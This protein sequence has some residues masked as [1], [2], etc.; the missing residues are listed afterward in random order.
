MPLKKSRYC[1]RQR[2][3][4]RIVPEDIQRWIRECNMTRRSTVNHHCK[5]WNYIAQR[6]KFSEEYQTTPEIRWTPE[7]L[8]DK[9]IPSI[10]WIVS[11]HKTIAK[12]IVSIASKNGWKI[13]RF[14]TVNEKKRLI[15]FFANIQKRSKS[16][17]RQSLTLTSP[18]EIYNGFNPQLITFKM[19][20]WFL[21]NRSWNYCSKPMNTVTNATCLIFLI[22]KLVSI[23]STNKG[24]QMRKR[25]EVKLR[26][27]SLLRQTKVASDSVTGV[28]HFDLV[29]DLSTMQA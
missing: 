3:L 16:V 2:R 9:N 12:V 13:E 23:G 19:G 28:V 1:P 29:C 11:S 25:F 18:A 10:S 7:L 5:S 20:T 21:G 8:E 6:E 14:G 22:V 15:R 17:A 4:K 26:D 24:R 27:L